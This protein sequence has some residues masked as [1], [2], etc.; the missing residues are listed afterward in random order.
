EVWAGQ[1]YLDFHGPKAAT[2]PAVLDAMAL[3]LQR[4]GTKRLAEV[5]A[6]TI[7]L[8][9]GFPMYH[10]LRETLIA[11]RANCERYPS[12][13]AVYYPGGRV[14]ELGEMFRQPDL[15]RTLRAIAAADEAE[16]QRSHDRGKA[17]EAGRAAFY[18]GEI[19]RRIV[20]ATRDAGGLLSEDDLAAF[21]GRLEEPVKT[22]YRGYEIYKA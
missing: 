9:D 4:F 10:L 21:R 5:L 15:A 20:K 12:T 14:P 22:T 3:V 19:A 6:P 2:V 1:P 17:I 8:A 7:D 16:W 18:T 11:E 13:M